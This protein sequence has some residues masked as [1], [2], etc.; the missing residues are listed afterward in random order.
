MATT[1]GPDPG[2]DPRNSRSSRFKL[3]FRAITLAWPDSGDD[4]DLWFSWWNRPPRHRV[5]SLAGSTASRTRALVR[6]GQIGDLVLG[7]FGVSQRRRDTLEIIRL[8]CLSLAA[9]RWRG[10]RE[11]PDAIVAATSAAPATP[12]PTSRPFG[13]GHSRCARPAQSSSSALVLPHP[14]EHSRSFAS[15][16]RCPSAYR[17]C[18]SS[19]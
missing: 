3:V 9:R 17:D 12:R 19:S 13:E 18:C 6:L 2:F 15:L 1:G 7:S 14:A 16:S 11:C 5:A 4:R 10:G 8:A